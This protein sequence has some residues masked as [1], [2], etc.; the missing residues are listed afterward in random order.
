MTPNAT[1]DHAPSRAAFA[2]LPCLCGHDSS[3]GPRSYRHPSQDQADNIY[4]GNHYIVS[5]ASE[6]R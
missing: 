4:Q 2:Y 5:L 3:D 1:I 6:H